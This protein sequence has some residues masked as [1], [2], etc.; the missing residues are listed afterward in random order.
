MWGQ[1]GPCQKHGAERCGR[2]AKGCR[3]TD[4]G[5]GQPG[6][7]KTR[8]R[9]QRCSAH[10][11]GTRRIACTTCRDGEHRIRRPP[12]AKPCGKSDRQ[13][14]SE[15]GSEIRTID[16]FDHAWRDQRETATRTRASPIWVVRTGCQD[17]SSAF[18]R[19]ASRR[20]DRTSDDAAR[21]TICAGNSASCRVTP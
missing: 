20:R 10:Q 17:R 6:K 1:S 19:I 3:S 21:P 12:D 13:S 15:L 4:R 2:F 16:Q 7:C 9:N 5:K 8:S 14:Q 18:D 11:I